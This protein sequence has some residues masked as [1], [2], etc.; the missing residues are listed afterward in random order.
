MPAKRR[1]AT[2]Q[3]LLATLVKQYFDWIVAERQLSGRT[4]HSY[5][6]AMVLFLRHMAD[7]T[8]TPVEQLAFADDLANHV[9]T[10]LRDLESQRGVS[11]ATRNHR[12]SVIRSF[13]RFVAYQQPLLAA[14][15]HRVTGIPLRKHE[16]K[17][18]D[19]FEPEEMEAMIDAASPALPQGR[20]NRALLLFLYNTGCRASELAGTTISDVTFERPQHVRLLGKGRRWRTVPLW[21]R[22]VVAI[23]QMLRDRNDD[24]AALFI[25]Q[26]GNTLTRYGV[27]YA[28]RQHAA[29][30]AD[31]YPELHKR[32][33]SPHTVRHTTAVALL[34]ATGDIDAVSKIL[35][36]ASLNTTRLYT[37]K[38]RSRL[39][40]TINRI[41]GEILPA[42][43]DAWAPSQDVIQWLQRL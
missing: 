39:A 42:E 25:G 6:D 41:A 21:A 20:R 15:C 24:K 7:S 18:L 12:L 14:A 28:V 31:K 13:C 16:Q 19:Y 10:F 37:A 3:I 4:V 27:L 9:L 43:H 8:R 32:R 30:V 22:T 2:D 40:E 1:C 36:H 17:L 35:G 38:D 34:R 33:L 23:Q 26:R 11:I 29:L 5:R